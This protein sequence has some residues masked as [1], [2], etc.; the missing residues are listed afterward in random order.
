MDQAEAE[1]D[2]HWLA[3]DGQ[4]YVS[5]RK[6]VPDG[7]FHLVHALIASGAYRGVLQSRYLA[8]K[9]TKV[10]PKQ[11]EDAAIGILTYRAYEKG[12]R[13][14]VFL[15]SAMV[16]D[17][18]YVELGRADGKVVKI[19]AAGYSVVGDA[20]VRFTR[21]SRGELPLPEQG[22]TLELFARHFNL[23]RPDLIRNIG[24]C[25]GSFRSAGP[26][27]ILL[28]EGGSG[29]GKSS[30][31]DR[32]IALTDPPVEQ[33]NARFSLSSDERNLH[34]HASHAKVLFFDN[35]S[36]IGARDADTLCRISTGASS[37]YR[38]HHTMT[39]ETQFSLVRPVIATCIATPSDRNDLLSRC[40][41]VTALPITEYRTEEE[42][43]R[44]FE[45]DRPK[46]LGFLFEAIS[47]A[48]RNRPEVE[49]ARADGLI[50]PP[51]LADFALFVEGASEIL[52]LRPGEFCALLSDE[53]GSMQAEAVLGDP[54]AEALI[55]YFSRDDATGIDKSARELLDL[56]KVG[57]R[58]A[59]FPAVNK[60]RG[61][62]DRIKPGL[63][64]NGIAIDMY[65]DRHAKAWRMRIS[66]TSAFT[67][68]AV[69]TQPELSRDPF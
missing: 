28:I 49:K 39:E 32:N 47:L 58:Y 31:G 45:A 46:M 21:G 57:N 55:T 41:R 5:F 17:V 62:L 50:K 48:L 15:R 60:L 53:Q 20:P 4:A 59:E 1:G 65:Q 16:G 24:F 42:L 37:S 14:S 26:F 7:E 66:R 12:T 3:Q 22:G 43:S 18:C 54:V 52:G 27:A 38:T 6:A 33:A 8:E 44:A 10:L 68:I 40:L 29:S 30:L 34:V 67:P 23:S 25:I 56:L 9:A 35:L 36:T 61:H 19:D 51:R 13:H 63:L 69:P 2:E 64:A 11:Q